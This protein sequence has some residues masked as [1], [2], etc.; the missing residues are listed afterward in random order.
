LFKLLK[1]TGLRLLNEAVK[2][3]NPVAGIVP[4]VT[5]VERLPRDAARAL[6][7][8]DGS[9]FKDEA[10]VS[11]DPEGI[12]ENG[13]AKLVKPLAETGLKAITREFN[14]LGGNGVPGSAVSVNRAAIIVL[15]MEEHTIGV[16]SD[17]VSA[18]GSGP[19]SYL[20]STNPSGG[21]N[22]GTSGRSGG[23]GVPKPEF[24]NI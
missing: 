24:Q 12:V 23:C 15:A 22:G 16:T 14:T 17:C 11:T 3:L 1:A 7:D 13:V 8:E 4:A 9:V 2:L 5:P 10:K 6:S 21:G 19:V 20:V 18:T